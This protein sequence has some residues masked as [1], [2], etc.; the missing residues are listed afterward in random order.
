MIMG[1]DDSSVTPAKA[2]AQAAL[3]LGPGPRRNDAE[4]GASGPGNDGERCSEPWQD[5]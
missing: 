3:P 5:L 4:E 2:G 1:S